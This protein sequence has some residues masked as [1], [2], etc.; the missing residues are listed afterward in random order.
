MNWV[1]TLPTTFTVT[2][3]QKNYIENNRFFWLPLDTRSYREGAEWMGIGVA[4][5]GPAV[6]DTDGRDER[7]AQAQLRL[8]S[9]AYY[10]S[11]NQ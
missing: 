3:P 9:A 1:S 8:R 2:S 6:P 7:G 5:S 4:W 10:K 11:R